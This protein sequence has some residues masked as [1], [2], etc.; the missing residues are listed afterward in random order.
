MGLSLDV[1]ALPQLPD[2]GRTSVD[3]RQPRGRRPPLEQLIGKVQ[4]SGLGEHGQQEWRRQKTGP[5]MRVSFSHQLHEPFSGSQ[6]MFTRHEVERER[7]DM[8]RLRVGREPSIPR[9]VLQP[10]RPQAIRGERIQSLCLLRV[11]QHPA[12]ARR[13]C[14]GAIQVG[15]GD[16]PLLT[17]ERVD[18]VGSRL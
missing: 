7:S 3:H 17:A 1:H 12:N 9:D 8:I 16:R 10:P 2:R 18:D 14:G 11:P 6:A 15:G 4:M 13:Q 5:E